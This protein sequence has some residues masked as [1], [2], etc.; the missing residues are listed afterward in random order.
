MQSPR[1]IPRL[2]RSAQLILGLTS[3]A[4]PGSVLAQQLAYF[5]NATF[6]T[7]M[8][9]QSLLT[10]NTAKP[11]PVYAVLDRRPLDRSNPCADMLKIKL[12]RVG[13]APT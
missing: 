12:R 11:P 1:P 5:A 8:F 6:A 10:V 4:L 7:S 13:V 3:L 2:L 9:P